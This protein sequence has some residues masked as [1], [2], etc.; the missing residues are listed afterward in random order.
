MSDAE[1]NS[2]RVVD[3]TQNEIKA[4]IEEVLRGQLKLQVGMNSKHRPCV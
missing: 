2:K 1:F 4:L 3:G